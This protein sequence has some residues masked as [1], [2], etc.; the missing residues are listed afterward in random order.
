MILSKKLLPWNC[1]KNFKERT[2]E[3]WYIFAQH[4]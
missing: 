2:L 4:E 3:A 1:E